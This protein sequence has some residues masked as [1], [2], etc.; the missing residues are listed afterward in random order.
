MAS[1]AIPQSKS[2]QPSRLSLIL[3]YLRRNPSLAIG[4]FISACSSCSC[5]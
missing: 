4:L 5:W 1:I 3:R 2:L